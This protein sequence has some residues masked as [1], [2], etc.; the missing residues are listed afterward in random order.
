VQIG[1]YRVLSEL[2]R[3]GM[4]VVFRAH[5]PAL[6]REVALKVLSNLGA[7]AELSLRFR[8]EAQA[9][10]R[11][12]HPG[13]VGV[14]SVGVTPQ[15]LPYLVM[16]LVEGESLAARVAREGPLPEAEAVRSF[17]ALARALEHAHG[18]GVLH[19]D[20]KPLNVLVDRDGLVLTDF[21]L[22]ALVTAETRLTRS[23]DTMGTPAYM[24]PEQAQ[25]DRGRLG[26][27]TDVHG[28]GATLFHALT[29]EPPF[30]GASA[31]EVLEAVAR[32]E[33]PDPRSLR[34]GLDP[35]LAA[36]VLTALAKEPSARYPTAEAFAAALAALRPGPGRGPRQAR[37]AWAVWLAAGVGVV[38]L[39]AGVGLGRATRDPDPPPAPT[40]ATTE[41]APLAPALPPTPT[42][43]STVPT[44]AA[45][46]RAIE[47]AE[48][49]QAAHDLVGAGDAPAARAIYDALVASD[50]HDAPARLARAVLARNGAA[51]TA[52]DLAQARADLEALAAQAPGAGPVLAERALLALDEGDPAR[53]L[54]LAA[55]ATDVAP[56]SAAAWG[57]R[58]LVE[59]GRSPERARDLYRRALE[60]D[61]HD[62]QA[63]LG[64]A[65]TDAA[66]GDGPAAIAGLRRA[67][68]R[69][70]ASHRARHELARALFV[71]GDREGAD[72]E[73]AA[74]R[75]LHPRDLEAHLLGTQVLLRA[76]RHA[77]GLEVAREAV[78]LAPTSPVALRVLAVASLTHGR[79]AEALTALDAIL[80][81]DPD[82]RD[83]RALRA[84][85]LLLA[86]RRDEAHAAAQEQLGESQLALAVEA[87]RL[88]ARDPERALALYDSA[89]GPSGGFS[90]VRL[91]RARLRHT[92]GDA[93]GAAED[94]A[95]ILRDGP[96][97]EA[98]LQR[99]RWRSERGD[100]GGAL[101]DALLAAR[102][103]R[104]DDPLAQE[105]RTLVLDLGAWPRP[106]TPG[107]LERIALA[108]ERV[109]A[110]V[111]DEAL[112][113]LEP[114]LRKDPRHPL[115]RLVRAR[116]LL[117]TDE[118]E[119]ARVELD[120]LARVASSSA[121]TH[122]SR[123][124]L[125]AR[126]RDDE[127][128]L[129]EARL[130]LRLDPTLG[131]AHRVL[132]D[133]LLAAGE[134]A[135]A[136]QSTAAAAALG[137]PE[138]RA[139]RT[140]EAMALE[141][142]EEALV[143]SSE[144]DRRGAGTELLAHRVVVLVLLGR[145]DE[146]QALLDSGWSRV[147][148]VADLLGARGD[149]RQARGDLEGAAAD[150]ELALR[151]AP[152]RADL[153]LQLLAVLQRRRDLPAAQRLVAEL[154]RRFGDADWLVFARA[155]VLAQTGDLA[156]ARREARAL[157]ASARS[158]PGIRREVERFLEDLDRA[159]RGGRR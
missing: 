61:P 53:A 25:G 108:A 131:L 127:A 158:R 151:A 105:V 46:A 58:A 79:P 71:S 3:G 156:G 100:L 31:L 48:R 114:V 6:D 148:G 10:A 40:V 8:R 22:A 130:A 113:A 26:P 15:G 21:G 13:I 115:A 84:L 77:E 97:P 144:A 92:R 49:L 24:A 90:A 81:T 60:L 62:P 56:G 145:L 101:D 89:L 67:V 55:E 119:A 135:E 91:A 93:A 54:A 43:P 159:E 149:L 12:R 87:D 103:L 109:G 68:A 116:A 110:G 94:L 36:V 2:G 51:T 137:L 18:R 39:V 82:D 33:V 104:D 111:A 133:A 72:K 59:T 44:P 34:P 70:P 132:A 147:Q 107:E 157:L 66:L 65:L 47:R 124:Q 23:G 126:R 11:L 141:R 27:A 125:L 35:A 102:A 153:A 69:S 98:L 7:D 142:L 75:A 20:L 155:R 123:A 99:A 85:A 83:L 86:G 73:A 17:E 154:T 139:L 136:Q 76:N 4:G 120:G 57:T 152:G 32:N 122:A 29:G 118:L 37:A 88:T 150:C 146:A 41:R 112:A 74:L 138:A 106:T 63:L 121:W 64:L 38:A 78:R 28:L 140:R 143:A 16:D 9:M 129:A 134:P 30:R 1:P 52:P 80:Q 5:D 96:D 50:E 19:R 42:T 95:T 14:H 45:V 117:A 128:A